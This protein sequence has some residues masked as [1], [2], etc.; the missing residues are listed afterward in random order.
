MNSIIFKLHTIY[1]FHAPHL[2]DRPGKQLINV[3]NKDSYDHYYKHI[4][5]FRI[6][7]KKKLMKLL[8]D[9]ND[10]NAMNSYFT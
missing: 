1:T 2:Y 7:K 6:K 9:K 10:D 8:I 3:M 4:S 5:H